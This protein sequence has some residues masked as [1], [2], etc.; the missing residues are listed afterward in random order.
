MKKI[1]CKYKISKFKRFMNGLMFA[2]ISIIALSLCIRGI[3]NTTASQSE[4]MLSFLTG[5]IS[6]LMGFIS[7]FHENGL[8]T[9]ETEF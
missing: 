8:S 9:G 4:I 1:V 2:I 7:M 6:L 5:I 3:S